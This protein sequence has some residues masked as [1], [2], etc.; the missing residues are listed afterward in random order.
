MWRASGLPSSSREMS[1]GVEGS[2]RTLPVIHHTAMNAFINSF[3][4]E[5]AGSGGGG[6]RRGTCPSTPATTSPPRR[7]KSRLEHAPIPRAAPS[8]S[9][10][11]PEE[12]APN[13][14]RFGP[15]RR[16]GGSHASNRTGCQCVPGPASQPCADAPSKCLNRVH[17]TVQTLARCIIGTRASCGRQTLGS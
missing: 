10:V 13:N 8:N 17:H 16:A 15:P 2:S 1:S 9:N 12:M 6:A 7:T 11:P 5:S 3:T 4:A 14:R